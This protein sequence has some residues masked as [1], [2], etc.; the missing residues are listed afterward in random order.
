MEIDFKLLLS[1]WGAII[2]TVLGI[3]KIYEFRK[4]KPKIS[5]DAE[6]FY[7]PCNKEDDTYGVKIELQRGPDLLWHQALVQFTIRNSGNKPIQVISVFCETAKQVTQITT[8]ELP[9]VLDPNTQQQLNLQPEFFSGEQKKIGILD[10]L[11]EKHTIKLKQFNALKSEVGNLPLRIKNYKHKEKGHEVEA[12]QTFAQDRVHV[13][14][15]KDKN[16]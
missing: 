11:G 7:S 13:L 6:I 10:A 1:A 9:V 2:A 4:E 8:P 16:T 15:L 14:P 3:I 5:I 12:F